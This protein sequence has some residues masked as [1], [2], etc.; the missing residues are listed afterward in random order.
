MKTN[1]KPRSVLPQTST[2]A[3]AVTRAAA[4]H[5][6]TNRNQNGPYSLQGRGTMSIK[7]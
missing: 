4:L 5:S 3:K 6:K 2:V 1:G 7:D